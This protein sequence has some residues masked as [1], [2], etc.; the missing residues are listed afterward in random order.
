MTLAMRNVYLGIAVN[1][2]L[3][4][5]SSSHAVILYWTDSRATNPPQSCY[6]GDSGWQDEGQ[7]GAFLGTPIAPNYFI[8]AK[9]V[10]G[11]IGNT[12]MYN[13]QSYTTTAAYA[14]PNSDLRIWQVSST[15]PAYAPLYTASAEAG[16]TMTVFGRG[17]QRGAPV[18]V[19]G[20]T[21]GWLWGAGDGVESW[22]SN[23][24]ASTVTDPTYGQLLKFTFDATGDWHEGALSGGDSGG[25]VFIKDSGIWKLA[26]INLGVDG[27]FSLTGQNGTGFNAAIFDGSGLYY[28]GD[29]QWRLFPTTPGSPA[30]AGSYATRISSNLSWIDSVI[31]PV[32]MLTPEPASAVLLLLAATMCSGRRRR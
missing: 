17:T 10:G 8:T 12:F 23:T 3:L 2:L 5:A 25:A 1:L 21:K 27:P 28:G 11:S 22:G 7:W 32:A 9:H 16:Q 6:Y 4:S 31:G 19:D 18:I 14:S 13:G 15:F 20:Q 30:P 24:V 26:G 29:N